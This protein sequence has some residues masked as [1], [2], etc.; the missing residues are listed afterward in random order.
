MAPALNCFLLYRPPPELGDTG[1]DMS[2]TV[3]VN[4]QSQQHAVSV[5]S[6]RDHSFMLGYRI[7][8]ECYAR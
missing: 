4:L 5:S 6:K 7:P 2:W 8:E 1:Q 3:A